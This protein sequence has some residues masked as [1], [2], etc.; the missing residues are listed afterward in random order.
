MKSTSRATASLRGSS[1]K[2]K[3]SAVDTGSVVPRRASRSSPTSTSTGTL[4]SDQETWV[5]LPMQSPSTTSG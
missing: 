4:W 2:P 3:S 1:Q 5:S